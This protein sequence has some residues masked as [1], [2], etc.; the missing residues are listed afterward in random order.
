MPPVAGGP[1]HPVDIYAV[2]VGAAILRREAADIS[3]D[4]RELTRKARPDRLW[5]NGGANRDAN[6]GRASGG[7]PM[8]VFRSGK[9]ASDKF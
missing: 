1:V 2:T 4:R 6:D 5:P 9:T 3:G 8:V 7:H